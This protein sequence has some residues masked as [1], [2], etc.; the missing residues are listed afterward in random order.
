MLLG[1]PEMYGSYLKLGAPDRYD[2]NPIVCHSEH[3]VTRSS[4]EQ[5]HST[6]A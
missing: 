2:Q 4:S 5:A 3:L 6:T 1:A